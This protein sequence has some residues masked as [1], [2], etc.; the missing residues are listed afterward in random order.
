MKVTKALC[1]L[2]CAGCVEH[3]LA[4]SR[5]ATAYAIMPCKG[6]SNSKTKHWSLLMPFDSVLAEGSAETFEQSILLAIDGE[7]E[8]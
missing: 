6:N 7:G 2:T 8:Q 3:M 4:G 5:H 1:P